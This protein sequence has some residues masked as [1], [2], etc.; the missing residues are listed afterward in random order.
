[1]LSLV[2]HG[3]VAVCF[4]ASHLPQLKTRHRTLA[5]IA[6]HGLLGVF[7]FMIPT[8]FLQSTVTGDFNSLHGFLQSFASAFHIGLAYFLYMN[9]EHSGSDLE[10]VQPF[11]FAR[12][13]TAFICLMTRLFAA[14]HFSTTSTR[15]LLITD[16][17]LCCAILSD[18]VWFASELAH[19]VLAARKRTVSEEVQ[20]ISNRAA[21]WLD[22]RGSF[23][24]EN[25]LYGD[26]ALMLIFAMIHFAFPNHVLKLIIKQEEIIDS[27][28]VMWCR[29]FGA[30]CLYPAFASLF[31]AALQPVQQVDYL[32]SRLLTQGVIVFLNVW[33]HWIQGVYSA[34]HITGFMIS[35]LYASFLFSVYFRTKNHYGEDGVRKRNVRTTLE[36]VVKNK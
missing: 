26:A 21:I 6:A 14:Y 3:V 5:H 32:F 17:F 30:L 18:G 28:H 10:P 36:R 31:V 19:F 25:S 23:Y 8:F 35:A 24:L 22:N 13:M 20:I 15:G 11:L 33:G 27:H 29:V 2:P 12:G 16:S 7:Y 9:E 4:A 1:M 34:N